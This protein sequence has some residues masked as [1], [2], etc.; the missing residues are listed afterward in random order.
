MQQT[1]KL[2]LRPIKIGILFSVAT[3]IL[4]LWGPYPFPSVNRLIMAI[5]LVFCNVA[6]YYGFK[7]GALGV[8]GYYEPK[9]VVNVSSFINTL[10]VIALLIAIPKF[11]IYTRFYDNTVGQ[12]LLSLGTFLSGGADQLYANRQEI[13]NA[14]G[15]W[16]YINYGVVLFGAFH[17]MY[18]PLS[19]YFWRK[20]SL[21]VKA[22]TLFIWAMYLLQYVCTGT[23]V[24]IFDFFIMLFVINIIRNY[25][26]NMGR[27]KKRNW[28][29]IILFTILIF[30]VLYAFDFVMGSRIGDKTTSVPIGNGAV[31]LDK[32]TPLW[33]L[34]PS[35]L[36]PLLSYLT[37]YVALPY[38]A[39]A[40]SFEVPFETTFGIG[41]SWFLLDN[42]PFFS[43]D[44]W[45]RTYMMK[46]EQMFEYSHW[47]SW[48]TAYLW[49]ANDFSH[50]G[51]P[52]ILF[53]LFRVFGKSWRAYLANGNVLS[54]LF[55]MLFVKMIIYISANNQVFQPS[56][57]MFAFWMLLIAQRKYMI[58][59]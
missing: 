33:V 51:V 36:H 20:L 2:Y 48:H 12:T 15:I 30:V 14:I 19:M 1:N 22:G 32:Q 7:H 42:V 5:F 44:L 53:F 3:F 56:D 10:F 57:T 16:R 37:R 58:K 13:Q 17:W 41:H 24:G 47:S 11:V 50:F 59:E 9:K 8:R 31:Y 28:R 49:F 35:A 18:I 46:M 26:K 6:M 45:D 39:L 27:R 40:M 29:N 55:F 4:Y 52:I 23:N 25:K 54:L 38:H 43:A 34:T 21:L